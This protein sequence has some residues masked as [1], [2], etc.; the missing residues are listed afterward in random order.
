M[1]MQIGDI[2]HRVHRINVFPFL[3][4]AGS[5]NAT[6]NDLSD[7]PTGIQINA[8]APGRVETAMIRQIGMVLPSL[9]AITTISAIFNVL[10]C[11]L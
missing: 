9:S 3:Q 2:A 6:E 5:G 11:F 7:A 1:V 10:E 8:V 4:L